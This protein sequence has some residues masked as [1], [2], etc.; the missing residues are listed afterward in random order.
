MRKSTSTCATLAFAVGKDMGVNFRK[1]TFEVP[2]SD[3]DGK[4]DVNKD[5]G[6]RKKVHAVQNLR[7]ITKQVSASSNNASKICNQLEN[8]EISNDSEVKPLCYKQNVD[9]KLAVWRKHLQPKQTNL[10]CVKKF[11]ALYFCN[12]IKW[13]NYSHPTIN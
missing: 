10:V 12:F 8:D 13:A 2:G 11:N 5:K 3:G 7:Q 1:H 9:R 6:L 4:C